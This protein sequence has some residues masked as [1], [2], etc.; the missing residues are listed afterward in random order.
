MHVLFVPAAALAGWRVEELRSECQFLNV[1]RPAPEAEVA[2]GAVL[3]WLAQAANDSPRRM[4]D[5]APAVLAIYNDVAS[6]LTQMVI[7]LDIAD[8][9]TVVDVGCRQDMTLHAD[10]SK[11]KAV[12]L[13]V[14]ALADYEAAYGIKAAGALAINCISASQLATSGSHHDASSCVR[15]K[16]FPTPANRLGSTADS[17]YALS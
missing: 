13:L 15:S 4:L 14:R 8:E 2:A 6:D 7:R 9:I 16:A 11:S 3:A 12:G 10:L 5:V 1:Q 17:R